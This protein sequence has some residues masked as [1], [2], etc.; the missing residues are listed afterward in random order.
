M[1]AENIFQTTEELLGKE[2]IGHLVDR[3]GTNIF[4]LRFLC[5]LR[6]HTAPY[7]NDNTLKQLYLYQ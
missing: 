7:N 5:A 6:E 1:F 2:Q 3:K 4:S